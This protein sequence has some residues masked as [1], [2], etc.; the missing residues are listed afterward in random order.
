MYCQ[1]KKLQAMTYDRV[2]GAALKARPSWLSFN[3]SILKKMETQSSRVRMMLTHTLVAL[4]RFSSV[5]K[6]VTVFAEGT[7]IFVLFSTY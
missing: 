4:L 2:F 5:K 7:Y 1:K 6:D 3:H